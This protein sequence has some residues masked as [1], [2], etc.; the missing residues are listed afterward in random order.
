VQVPIVPLASSRM[1]GIAE[2]ERRALR[3][4]GL[5]LEYLTIA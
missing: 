3:R 5:L 2:L 1:S 4:R